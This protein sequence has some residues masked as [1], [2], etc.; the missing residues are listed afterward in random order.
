MFSVNRQRNISESDG[1]AN[2]KLAHLLK[3]LVTIFTLPR[4]ECGVLAIFTKRLLM[5]CGPFVKVDVI[6]MPFDG[7]LCLFVPTIFVLAL[8]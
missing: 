7:L 6:D 5:S 1:P 4:A 8:I 3:R 2:I